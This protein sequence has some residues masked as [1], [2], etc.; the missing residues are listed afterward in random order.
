MIKFASTTSLLATILFNMLNI[1]T[2]VKNC[3]HKIANENDWILFELSA[4]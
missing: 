1:F 3:F 4:K 2:N